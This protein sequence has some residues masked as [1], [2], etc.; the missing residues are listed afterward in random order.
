[1]IFGPL[2]YLPF[3]L[4]TSLQQIHTHLSQPHLTMGVLKGAHMCLVPHVR[5]GTVIC[6]SDH[7]SSHRY[8]LR[9]RR[10]AQHVT[11]ATAT[12]TMWLR[13]GVRMTSLMGIPVCLGV[14]FFFFPGFD[15]EDEVSIGTE[16]GLAS[17]RCLGSSP[18]E[19]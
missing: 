8:V 7:I 6:T 1:M 17:F 15:G 14:W 5:C 13:P 4:A 2:Q 3:T 18:P 9:G 16:L 12:G 19:P 10:Q 11:A